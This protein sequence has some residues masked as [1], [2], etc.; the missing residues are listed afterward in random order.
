MSIPMVKYL[1]AGENGSALRGRKRNIV[2]GE[3]GSR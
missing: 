3:G 2:P 1:C